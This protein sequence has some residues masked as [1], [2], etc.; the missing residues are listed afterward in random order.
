MNEALRIILPV[1]L[2][3]FFL[4][5]FVG[6]S[7]LVWKRTGINPYVVGKT[8]RPIDFVE[9]YYPVPTLA[10]LATTLT[11][12]LLPQFYQYAS[13]IVWLDV[14]W[15]KVA[16]LALMAIALVWTATAQMQM[17][18]SW[19]I[20]IDAENKTELVEKGLFAVSRNPIFL[21][22]RLALWGFFLTLPSA[23]SLAA[24]LLADLLMQIQVR[25]EEEFLRGEHGQK[26]T[27]FCVRVR[28]WI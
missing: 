5:A 23:V 15:I 26:Y 19:R 13:P 14:F 28:R 3:A 21:G 8:N 7:Y 24:V 9:G 12:S 18:K 16:G 20:G 10:I 27:E 22:M 4:I 17:G 1:Y 6:R 11:Y 2:A 25:L